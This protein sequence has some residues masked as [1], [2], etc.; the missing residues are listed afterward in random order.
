MSPI[1]SY[2]QI[3]VDGP[4]SRASATNIVHNVVIGIDNYAGPTAANNEVP[5]GAK[6]FKVLLLIAFSQLV[7]ISSLTHLNLQY[8]RSGQAAITPGAIGGNPQRNQVTDTRMFFMGRDQNSNFMMLVKVPKIY[9]RIREG[10]VWKLV[11]RSD[12]VFTSA[13]Q[14][15]YKFYR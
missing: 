2:K 8:L 7:N 11:Y 1:Q 6:I 3:S 10:D 12:T 4:A 13:T 5:T 9:Q 15:I 14:A